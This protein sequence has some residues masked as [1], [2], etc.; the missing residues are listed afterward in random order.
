MLRE[1]P[2]KQARLIQE[3]T[4][5]TTVAAVDGMTVL[6]GSRLNIQSKKQRKKRKK[7]NEFLMKNF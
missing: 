1:G 3:K 6:F 7:S 5:V 2:G 4:G